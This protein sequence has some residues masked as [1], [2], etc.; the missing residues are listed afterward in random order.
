MKILKSSS[1]IRN[2]ITQLM[3]PGKAR[4]VAIVAFVGAG[5]R[6]FIPKAKGVELICWPRAG[7]TNP[8]ELRRL[9]KIGALIRF[10]DRLHMKVYWAAGRGTIITS[11][12]LTTNALGSGGLKEVGV[13]LPA[14]V[15]DVDKLIS[16]LNSRPFSKAEI[17][18]LDEAHRKLKVRET[19]R[20][21]NENRVDYLEWYSL[22][23][24]E[25]WKLGWWDSYGSVARAARDIARNEYNKREPEDFISC[26]KEDFQKNDCV[27]S[28]RV[29]KKDVSAPKWLFIDR[30]VRVRRTEKKAYFADYPY[31]AIQ[32]WTTRHYSPP[33]FVVTP[34][35]RQALGAACLKHGIDQLK[36]MR[37]TRPPL[38]L[39][40][41]IAME[42]NKRR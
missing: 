37:S 39:L 17:R 29:T 14:D 13:L 11:A 2:A 38:G 15:V 34:A 40:R 24:R 8:L 4:R 23:A 32:V 19:P 36:N 27:L 3:R 35:F 12:N 25:P 9:K 5:A 41:L 22:P 21:P 26:R 33:P 7:G 42:M 30:V 1:S 31:Q 18:K 16:S 6:A 10:A 20:P 28:V